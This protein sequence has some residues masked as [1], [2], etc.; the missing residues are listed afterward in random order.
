LGQGAKHTCVGDPPQQMLMSTQASPAGQV[1]LL[2]QGVTLRQLKLATQTTLPSVLRLQVQL[3]GGPDA[4]QTV[5]EGPQLLVVVA[6][7]VLLG[8]HEPV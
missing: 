7:Q 4:L 5:E 3:F 8:K 2:A 1:A 6:A